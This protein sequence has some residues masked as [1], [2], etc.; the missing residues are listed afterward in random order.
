MGREP[1]CAA[2]RRIRVLTRRQVLQSL[3]WAGA[4]VAA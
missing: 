1:A 4:G 2:S 3:V